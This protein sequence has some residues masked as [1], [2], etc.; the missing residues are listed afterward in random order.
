VLKPLKSD[1][2]ILL[3]LFSSATLAISAGVRELY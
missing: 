1:S 2:R 3:A